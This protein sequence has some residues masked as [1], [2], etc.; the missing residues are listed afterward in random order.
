L[1]GLLASG[2]N[3]KTNESGCGRF[4]GTLAKSL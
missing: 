3:Y 2:L 1:S 4:A